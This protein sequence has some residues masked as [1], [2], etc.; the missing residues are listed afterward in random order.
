MRASNL[1]IAAAMLSAAVG[2]A[3]L[4]GRSGSG[5]GSADADKEYHR[6]LDLY[7]VGQP[8]P[9]AGAKLWGRATSNDYGIV[10]MVDS[11][12]SG[13]YEQTLWIGRTGEHAAALTCSGGAVVSK[14][15]CGETL[16]IP[17]MQTRDCPVPQRC[18]WGRCQ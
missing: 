12:S 16:C 13:Q 1:F 4:A 10:G 6:K 2:C 9:K 11:T 5:G 17:C 7:G 18:H 14:V 3:V 15:L 8:C